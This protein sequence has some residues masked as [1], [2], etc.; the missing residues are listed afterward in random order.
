MNL[1][2]S[3]YG[4]LG[5][6]CLEFLRSGPAPREGCEFGAREQLSQ[7]TSYLDASMVYS[8]NAFH[9]DSLRIFRN[10]ER[11]DDQ[12]RRRKKKRGEFNRLYIFVKKKKKKKKFCST[13]LT[14]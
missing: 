10:G 4:P 2:D 11:A 5:V 13:F 7:V 14:A 3:F 8:S 9:S 12:S 1:R 6:R